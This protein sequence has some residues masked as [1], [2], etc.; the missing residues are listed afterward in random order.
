MAI[1]SRS[2]N[3]LFCLIPLKV[4]FVQGNLPRTKSQVIR[5]IMYE[6]RAV[7][8]FSPI[9]NEQ[10]LG[11]Q[12]LANG[13]TWAQPNANNPIP[14]STLLHNIIHAACKLIHWQL[15]RVDPIFYTR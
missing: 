5:Q 15:H 7:S 10:D 8:G 6:S 2:R 4:C 13:R 9:R 11:A 3:V 14:C 1:F 12:A